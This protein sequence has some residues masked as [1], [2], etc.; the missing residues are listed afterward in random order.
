[1]TGTSNPDGTI[2][3]LNV[4]IGNYKINTNKIGYE[5]NS[6]EL[7]VNLGMTTSYTII[8][9]K[10]STI[11]CIASKS[12]LI[13]G[14]TVSISGS[15][16]PSVS[17]QNVILTYTG[18]DNSINERT[19]QTNIN[20]DYIDNYTPQKAGL[21]FVQT[22]WIGNENYQGATSQSTSFTIAE[23][24][25][26]GN[27]KV[28]IQDDKGNPVSGATITSIT[29]PTN[30]QALTGYSSSDGTYLFSN[31]IIGG[32]TIKASRTDYAEN[33]IQLIVLNEQTISQTIQ[34]NKLLTK[35]KI[36]VKT[37]SGNP[38]S[39]A[40]VLSTSQPSGQ[41]TLSG[42]TAG[43]GSVIFN[44]VK[45]GTYT[46]MASKTGY[47][48]KSE[49]LSSTLGETTE[50]TIILEAEPQP[51]GGIPGYPIESIFIG[52]LLTIGFL[53]MYRRLS[54]KNPKLSL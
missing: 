38:M 7:A 47:K 9:K 17:S 13:Q 26:R 1:M 3:F 39:E 52:I 50:K 54:E 11:T 2:S 37:T 6:I 46:F 32:Y 43:D 31:I 8:L 19:V 4:L 45:F 44:D 48:S 35:V 14:E 25:K 20:G 21:W 34:I 42:T 33:S 22:S 10:Q 5:K 53:L 51:S 40:S 15:I 29:Q 49:S 27:L 30:Q 24:P 28:L 12:N 41:A 18:P 36:L 23:P 16:R